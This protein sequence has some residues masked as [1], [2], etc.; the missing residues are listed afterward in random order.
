VT[1][2]ELL[3]LQTARLKG[4]AKPELA[5]QLVPGAADQIRELERAGRLRIVPTGVRLTREGR[6]RLAVLV[7]QEHERTDQPALSAL[8]TE[9]DEPNTRIKAAVTS[10]Q[11]HADGTP[12]DH[13]DAAYDAEVIA[14]LSAINDDVA[15]LLTQLAAVA[16]RLGH[17]P[18]RLS[19]AIARAA[20][21]DA[22][23][24]ANPLGDSFHQIWFELHE[25][26]LGLLAR[27]REA[28]AAAGRAE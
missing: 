9:F 10:W 21:G 3:L 27:S 20:A 24:V 14:R 8:Y 18:G 19:V 7:Q 13:T 23:A 2:A 15:P 26:L 28:E 4:V 16:P 11:L 17:Y 25:D 6:D 1:S 22:A 12:N 5:E